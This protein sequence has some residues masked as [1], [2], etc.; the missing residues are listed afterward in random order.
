VMGRDSSR[1]YRNH[2]ESDI[3]I[4]ESVP[5]EPTEPPAP[6]VVSRWSERHPGWAAVVYAAV[7][8]ALAT[9]GGELPRLL[10]LL[11][12]M[13]AVTIVILATTALSLLFVLS[14]C[15]TRLPTLAYVA[16]FLAS[17][18]LLLLTRPEVSA[19]I[20]AKLHL[21]LH[22]KIINVPG[23]ILIGNLAL[24]LWAALFGKFLSR[25]IREGNLLLPVTVAAALV[26]VVTVFWG[27]V[28]HAAKNSPQVVQALSA[29][30]PV[31]EVAQN[32]STPILTYIGIGDFMFLALFLTVA[33][34][35]SMR[36]AATVWATFISMLVAAIVSNETQHDLPGLPFMMVSV[37]WVN[38]RS[39]HFSKEEKR[40]LVVVG[41]IVL[42]L[43]L[44][45]VVLLRRR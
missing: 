41:G 36:P 1:P 13:V 2:M 44:V 32:L 5:L 23:A 42:A 7:Y 29:Q 6:P 20:I 16:L 43:I 31:M 45:G 26:D 34:R 38:R 9:I 22:P 35:F 25:I 14:I 10:P 24:I 8:L 37:L 33:I 11:P 4:E 15:R 21:P 12:L 27:P 40:A 30:A 19:F 28:G 18:E 17:T 39:F 3:P